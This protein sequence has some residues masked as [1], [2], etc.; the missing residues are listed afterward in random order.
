MTLTKFEINDIC[1]V[2]LDPLY[3]RLEKSNKL[4]ERIAVALEQEN[5]TINLL[6][7]TEKE[8]LKENN[9]PRKPTAEIMGEIT[10]KYINKFN[11]KLNKE[12]NEV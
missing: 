5:S 12:K 11:K 3:V 6:S 7:E 8:F 1:N 2:V 9:K 10:R 4:L